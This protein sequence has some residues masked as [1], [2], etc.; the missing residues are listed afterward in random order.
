LKILFVGDIVGRGGR[1]VL[2]EKLPELKEE[3]GIDFTIVNVENSAGGFGITALIGEQILGLG[4]DVMTS[5]N[6]IW[7]KKESL[8][9]L[10]TEPR[11][12]RPGNY[13]PGAPG[14]YRHIAESYDGIKVAVVNIQGRVFMP[15]IDCPFR[16]MEQHLP[17]L[18]EQAHVVIVDLHAEATSEKMA[19]G[20]FLDGK[21]T[22]VLGTHTHIPT[23][24][25]R[26]L[27][28]GTA[29]ITD[30]GMTGSYDSV[31]GMK[32]DVSLNR[33]LTGLNT[34]FEPASQD[35]RLCGVIIDVDDVTGKARSIT[36]CQKDLD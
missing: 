28:E 15:T 21:V 18:R 19:M 8:Q 14:R 7:D 17:S 22:A 2:R 3:H 26:I 12:I 20:W 1:Q 13:P 32:V 23:A 4:V 10:D 30:V 11:L 34:R 36:R 9:Y 35:P 6:H 31:I 33:F 16:F 27:P 29:Y 5:G 24:D 25:T